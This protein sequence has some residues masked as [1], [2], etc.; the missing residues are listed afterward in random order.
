MKGLSIVV[1]CYNEAESLPTLVRRFGEVMQGRDDV[2]VIFVNNG[3]T[4][5]SA[6]V[7]SGELARTVG[8]WARSVDVSRNQGYGFGI[9]A[10][11]REAR[12]AF[13]GWTHADSQYDP[14]IC[15]EAY[16]AIQAAPHPAECV[17]KGRRQGRP[18]FDVIF[19]A[20]MSVVASALLGHRVSDVNAQPKLFHR[21]LLAELEDAPHDF[22]LDLFLLVTARRLGYEIRTIPVHFGLRE[23]GEAK[24][25]GSAALKWK[26]TRRTLD[27]VWKLRRATS[28]T[29]SRRS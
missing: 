21:D 4:D 13:V 29:A 18:A 23:H 25:G 20:G 16:E 11:L 9:L 3:S 12:G 10:G 19:T 6:E 2:E 14:R 26:L 22:S 24:G 1:P 27:F 7:L 28:R 17:V 8:G 15:L 5:A